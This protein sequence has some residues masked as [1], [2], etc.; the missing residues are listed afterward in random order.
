MPGKCDGN[1]IMAKSFMEIDLDTLV[2][3]DPA[4][5]SVEMLPSWVVGQG[6]PT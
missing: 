1:A 3:V 5:C 4:S 6:C 2:A